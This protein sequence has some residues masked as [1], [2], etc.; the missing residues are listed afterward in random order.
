[1]GRIL[2]MHDLVRIKGNDVFTDSLVIAEGTGN[3]HK[4]VKQTIKDYEAR[5][6]T[7]G[8]LSFL[9]RESTGGRP[10]E[11]IELNEPQASFVITLLRNNDVTVDFKL[12][13]VSE[14]YRMRR[15]LLEKQTA[16]WQ[17]SRLDGKK[18]RRGET[19][20]ILTKLIPLAES[21]GS[22]NAGKLYMAYSKLV[23]ATLGID[24]GQRDKLPLAYVDAIRF[25][26]RLISN[27]V[28]QEANKQT[29]YKEIYQVCKAKCS[30]AKE[31]SFLPKLER[32]SGCDV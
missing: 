8:T 27:I 28:S 12:A 29:H 13:L 10:E 18:V 16:D 19:D 21:Q 1:L 7:L 17:Q 14:F 11:I 2:F 31:L 15:F 22:K 23:N 9:K 26:E 25:M 30:I 5:I 32:L 3:N 4:S 20:V 6:K 24:A